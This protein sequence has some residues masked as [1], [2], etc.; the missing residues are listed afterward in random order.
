M[1]QSDRPYPS[2]NRYGVF[3][4]EQCEVIALTSEESASTKRQRRMVSPTA[5]IFLVQA[6]PSSWY[7]AAGYSLHSGG[8]AG[9]Y[10]HRRAD[11]R[12]PDRQ[13]ALESMVHHLL[14][15]MDDVFRT[16]E[17]ERKRPLRFKG[18]TYRIALTELKEAEVVARWAAD[19]IGIE[20]PE[21]LELELA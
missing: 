3:L 2:P 6:G 18:E 7:A 15:A 5:E 12:Y 20:A 17:K 21:Q 10:P 9:G 16:S 11:Q 8:G 4:P 13:S 19:L 1:K 14:A